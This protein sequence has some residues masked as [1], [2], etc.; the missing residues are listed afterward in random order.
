[1]RSQAATALATSIVSPTTLRM[2]QSRT[3]LA[4]QPL[5]PR[6]SL[7]RP[8]LHLIL[9]EH[10]SPALRRAAVAVG[11]VVVAVMKVVLVGQLFAR[12]NVANRHT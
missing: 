5:S 3:L 10:R 2:Q 11:L 1:M 9:A 6:P 4:S 7:S 8:P 12:S